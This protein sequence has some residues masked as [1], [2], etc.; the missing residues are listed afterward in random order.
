MRTVGVE[1]Y[2]RVVYAQAIVACFIL[3]V[4][5]GLDISAVKEVSIYRSDKPRLNEIVSSVLIIKTLLSVLSLL[6]LTA[7]VCALPAF[8][9][10]ARML[11]FAFLA[12]VADILLPVWYYQGM[13]RMKQ[14]T[15]TR[16]FSIA[17]YTAAVFIFIRSEADYEYIPL[18]Y[19]LGLIVSALISCHTLF[20]GDR[21]RIYR[22][23]TAVVKRKFRE[24]VPF[25]MS[26][27]SLVINS[28][29]A[30]IMCGTFLSNSD[31]AAFDVVQKIY[32]GAMIPMQMYNQALYPNLAKSQDK[33]MLRRSV[34]IAGLLVL[35]ITCGVFLLSDWVTSL[36]SAGTMPQAAVLM[37]II[38]PAL[39]M[40][41]LS[42]FFGSS[43][44]IVFGY[45]R[46][47]NLS[48]IASSAVL[49]ACYALMALTGNNSI[50]LYAWTLVPAEFT[51]L[52][53]RFACCRKYGLLTFRSLFL[54]H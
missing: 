49:F 17:F 7:L 15:A 11:Y 4:N 25:F 51:V 48:V 9:R 34:R 28:Y 5:F 39:F 40:A 26:R 52:A 31:A 1:N 16:F 41:G 18:L 21:I 24:S 2:G 42:I 6:L 54:R 46:P 14:L 33:T 43:A 19:S 20:V 36:L 47:F 23:P 45:Q 35:S 30:K 27:A 13:E 38:C 32:N 3:I 37:R 8:Q 29:M 10:M 50:Y 12:C 22:P 53:Y 44:L